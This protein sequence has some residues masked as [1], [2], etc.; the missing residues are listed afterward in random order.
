M[1]IASGCQGQSLGTGETGCA[2][3]ASCNMPSKRQP[4]IDDDQD[5]PD[6][7]REYLPSE[8]VVDDAGKSEQGVGWLT[9][10]VMDLLPNKGL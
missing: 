2:V 9:H 4:G 8:G 5:G 3:R 7:E 6:S 1:P 10:E